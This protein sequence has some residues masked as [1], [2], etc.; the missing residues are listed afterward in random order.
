[1]I[2]FIYSKQFLGRLGEWDLVGKLNPLF[3]L[4]DKYI[5]HFTLDSKI[6]VNLEVINFFGAEKNALKKIRGY[7]F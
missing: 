5:S 2:E 3:K 1:M 4:I 6:S 7:F